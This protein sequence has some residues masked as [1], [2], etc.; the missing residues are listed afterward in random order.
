MPLERA[1]T[2]QHCLCFQL[3]WKWGLSGEATHLLCTLCWCRKELPLP[4]WYLKCFL[5]FFTKSAGN[6][7]FSFKTRALLPMF[8]P[9]LAE[10]SHGNINSSC[11]RKVPSQHLAGQL[12]KGQ[13]VEEPWAC[14][15]GMRAASSQRAAVNF[16]EVWGR[17]CHCF[18]PQFAWTVHK[19]WKYPQVGAGCSDSSFTVLGSPS[20]S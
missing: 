2:G 16:C 4:C 14:S 13:E 1:E 3:E 11:P 18:L 5:P 15:T 12:P 10:G 8:P 6:E 7:P 9:C 17:F 20:C 19:R